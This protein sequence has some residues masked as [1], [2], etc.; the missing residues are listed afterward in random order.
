MQ[1]VPQIL[2]TEN[3]VRLSWGVKSW[4]WTEPRDLTKAWHKSYTWLSIALI[5]TDKR[6]HSQR[7]CDVAVTVTFYCKCDVA[8][9]FR[10]GPQA[11]YKR[12]FCHVL[13]LRRRGTLYQPA[14]LCK[15][16]TCCRSHGCQ[17]PR[18]MKDE[19]SLDRAIFFAL[20]RDLPSP[21]SHPRFQTQFSQSQRKRPT[22]FSFHPFV[23]RSEIPP[24]LL[25]VSLFHPPGHYLSQNNRQNGA[26]SV[27]RGTPTPR[28]PQSR[29]CSLP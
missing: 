23:A 19:G 14:F 29:A 6:P 8:K 21:S 7:F 1:Q 26:R 20:S 28:T 4:K 5:V 25:K 11:E 9:S 22:F 10:M 16:R 2:V 27:A 24:S 13:P 15:F 17:S 18:S 12:D 3:G